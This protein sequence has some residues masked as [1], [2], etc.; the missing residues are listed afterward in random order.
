MLDLDTRTAVLRLHAE[1]HGIRA[2]ARAVGISRQA[3][4]EILKSGSKEA[5]RLVRE[6]KAEPYLAQVQELYQECCGNMVRVWEELAAAGVE[7]SYST[8]T[9]F[10]RR[11]GIGVAPKER[12]G[13]YDFAPGVEMQHD[14][15]PHQ[16]VVD[17]KSLLLQCASLVLCYSR[18]LYA[19]VYPTFNRFWCKVFLTEA[20]QALGGS[21][22][23]CMLDNSSVVIAYGTGKN[24]VPAPE[25]AAFA[26]RFGFTFVAHEK[27]DANRSG[28]VERPF[29][30]IENNFYVGR[31]FA[32]VTDLNR[33]LAE[34]CRK[35]N[36]EFKKHIQAVP[37]ELYQAERT[38]LQP[39]PIY[40]PEVLEVCSRMVDLEGYVHLQT[41]RYSVPTELLGRRVEVH[42]GKDRVRVFDG[43]R[44]MVDHPRLVDKSNCRSTLPE[45]TRRGLWRERKGGAL[46]PLPEEAA[47]QTAGPE[48]SAFLV[49][50][51]QRYQNRAAWHVKRLHRM[52][53]DY[54]T[55]ALSKACAEALAYGL[56]DLERI[57]R[58]VLKNVAGD[59]F[60]MSPP[61]EGGNDD[62]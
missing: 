62:Q 52:F 32:D 4:R 29:H 6:E 1:G 36:G 46:P 11:R 2:L 30:Y 54:P 51:K 19:Q 45:H 7:L 18:M 27:G 23:R 14:T 26:Q 57:E 56:W 38:V 55:P 22:G 43:H 12:A 33:Q 17:G 8:L 39:L 37:V 61:R 34:W 21:A 58:M 15:S 40:V 10:C 5:P 13:R 42:G 41:N 31:K 3:V 53:L 44:L 48:V 35:T 9:G 16:V 20:L 25:M 28:R 50:L 59:F 24:A 47:L 60:R 49:E